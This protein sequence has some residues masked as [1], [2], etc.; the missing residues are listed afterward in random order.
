MDTEAQLEAHIDTASALVGLTVAGEHRPGVRAFL[1]VA[2]GFAAT[3]EGAPLDPSEL[4]FAPVYLP[5]DAP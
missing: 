3:L 1:A 2:A 5:P 4:A